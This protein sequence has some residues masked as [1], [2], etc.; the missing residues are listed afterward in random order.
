MFCYVAKHGNKDYFKKVGLRIKKLRMERS[1]TAREVTYDVGLN[2][3]R[4]ENA[5]DD[6]R[7]G[8]ILKLCDYFEITIQE[9]FEGL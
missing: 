3:G 2:I 4:I 9:F 6:I 5:G 8:S 7:L 1:L